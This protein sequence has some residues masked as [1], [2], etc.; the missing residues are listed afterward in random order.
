MSYWQP[1]IENVESTA[2]A[3]GLMKNVLQKLK[4]SITVKPGKVALCVL[5]AL[6]GWFVMGHMNGV[7]E[8][9]TRRML[10]P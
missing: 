5:L 3:L 1:W 9:L 10:S 4:G 2:D 8:A 6:I 7:D